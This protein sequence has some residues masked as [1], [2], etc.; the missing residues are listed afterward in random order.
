MPTSLLL[1]SLALL[2][3][4]GGAGCD[5]FSEALTDESPA[6]MASLDG[7]WTRTITEERISS[8]GTVAPTGTPPSVDAFE[9]G[10]RVN[11]N[12]IELT[13]VSDGDRVAVAYDPAFPGGSRSCT[14]IQA[15]NEGR[16]IVLFGEG[17]LAT[18]VSGTIRERSR[19]RHVWHFYTPLPGG[20]ARREVWTLTPR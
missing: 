2:V 4:L 12:F 15:D 8:S 14:V 18:D 11:C 13:N 1:R 10:R 3:A 9:V 20:E 7:T 17:T 6:I 16:R 19:Q 5:Y